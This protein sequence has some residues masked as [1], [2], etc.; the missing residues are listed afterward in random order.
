MY[1]NRFQDWLRDQIGDEPETDFADRGKISKQ[2]VNK[3]LSDKHP[4]N[5]DLDILLGIARAADV[6]IDFILRL[7]GK[8]EPISIG[9]E[10]AE[11]LK[12]GYSQLSPAGRH[13]IRE[14]IRFKNGYQETKVIEPKKQPSRRGTP[15]RNALKEK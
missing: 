13:E 2:V 6:Y 4:V 11:T 10:E 5:P 3:Y 8:L 14:M 15:A 12:H 1:W 9:E 7:I